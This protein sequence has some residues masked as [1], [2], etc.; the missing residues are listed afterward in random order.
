L[1]ATVVLA[2]SVLV[3]GLG[4]AAL[5]RAAHEEFASLPSWRLAQQ[6]L[7]APQFEMSGPTL[8]MLRMEA[9][10]RKTLMET[11]KP[12]VIPP[13]A[14]LLEP[15]RLEPIRLEAMRPEAMRDVPEAK[16]A[17][18]APPSD[19][20]A[21]NA[22]SQAGDNGAPAH[23]EQSPPPSAPAAETV[24]PLNAQASIEAPV[25]AART[26]AEEPNSDASPAESNASATEFNG[27]EPIQP[28]TAQP[29]PGPTVAS[30]SATE[31]SEPTALEAIASTVRSS[32]ATAADPLPQPVVKKATRARA[33]ARRRHAIARARA[34]ARERARVLLQQQGH[35]PDPF[36]QI[37]GGSGGGNVPRPNSG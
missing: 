18:A 2:V 31:A 7:L 27:V 9:P 22:A 20:T 33:I 12:E 30:S 8:A 37:F 25:A 35:H 13:E 11:V 36:T 28:E 14:P 19:I 32:E 4:A 15:I 26:P 10:G 21:P 29:E 24:A 17:E 23:A 3:F 5:L 1:F 34:A 16:P 6:P